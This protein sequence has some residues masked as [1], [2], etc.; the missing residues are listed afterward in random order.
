M[1]PRLRKRMKNICKYDVKAV[2]PW[3]DFSVILFQF[4]HQFGVASKSI[5]D[6]ILHDDDY[7][8]T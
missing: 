2:F 6:H 4:M 5:S 7:T 3:R 1:P 8:K